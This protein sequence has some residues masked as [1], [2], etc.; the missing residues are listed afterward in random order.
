VL[1]LTSEE[2]S[3]PLTESADVLEYLDSLRPDRSPLFPEGSEALRKV[4]DLIAHVHQPELSTNLILLQA[5]DVSELEAKKA[6]FWNE[7]IGNRQQKPLQYSAS[8]PEVPLCAF[9]AASHGAVYDIYTA[10][11]GECK[12]EEF[13][14]ETHRGYEGFAAGLDQLDS[15]LVLPLAAGDN[16]TLADLHIVPWLAHAL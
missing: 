9:R 10:E 15:M 4:K 2:L 1:S 8:H 12:R 16:L 7:F 6:S 5:R 14:A 11:E 3:G 13:S